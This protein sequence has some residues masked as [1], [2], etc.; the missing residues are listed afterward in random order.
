MDHFYQMHGKSPDYEDRLSS[1]F[2]LSK[3]RFFNSSRNN[4][5]NRD[6]I[7]KALLQRSHRNVPAFVDKS[8]NI[9]ALVRSLEDQFYPETENDQSLEQKVKD[10][11]SI[12]LEKMWANL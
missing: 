3:F 12:L 5:R 6:N 2:L 8:P 7:S 4:F 9:S 1:R 10:Q 11:H